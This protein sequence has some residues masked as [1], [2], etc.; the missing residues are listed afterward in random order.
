M[1][2]RISRDLPPVIE[3]FR[4]AGVRVAPIKGVAYATGLY[5]LPTER[6]MT[7]VDLL[8]EPHAAPSARAVL[9]ELG[10]GLVADTAL[11]HASTWVRRDLVID[12][13]RNIL[14]K[15]RSQ[16]DLD[17]VWARMSPG[18]PPGAERLDPHDELAFHL[19]HMVRNRLRG[20]LIQVVD[21]ARLAAR[22]S[23]KPALDRARAWGVETAAELAWSYVDAIVA[24][25]AG[26]PA[27]WLG[28]DSDDALAMRQPSAVRKIVFDIATAGSLRQLA[29]RVVDVG[30]ARIPRIGRR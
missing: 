17:A 5:A 18:W 19:L 24:D 6:P 9:G 4:H 30:A 14:A 21:A 29:A 28:P 22:S 20:P 2:A 16:I 25:R 13:H 10:F 12:L 27:G 15:G 26:R 7:D 11:H 8:V 1:W 23:P 3:R